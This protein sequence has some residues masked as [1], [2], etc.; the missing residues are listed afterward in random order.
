MF[1]GEF[2]HA[3]DDKGRVTIPSRWREVLGGHSIS[4]LMLTRSL[5]PCLAL[6]PPD[7]WGRIET[8]I[9]ELSTVDRN[10]RQY[11]R[12]LF[13]GAVEVTPDRAGRILIPASLREYAGIT[14]EVVFAGISTFAEVWA[15]DRWDALPKA[16]L[17][18]GDDLS[19]G[20]VE[21]GL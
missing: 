3:L 7:E 9:R 19:S 16:S 14:R 6:Y 20:L 8:R 2:E 1:Y 12:Q 10:A 15:K 11:R 5:D 21:L 18:E 13:S 17:N 4:T